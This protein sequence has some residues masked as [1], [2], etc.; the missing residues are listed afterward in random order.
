MRL[1]LNRFL[2]LL[3]GAAL[4]SSLSLG[5][6][7]ALVQGV[8]SPKPD[9][10][11]G[12]LSP[13][14]VEFFEKKIRPVLVKHCDSCHSGSTPKGGLS[15][16]TRTGILKGGS[17]GPAAVSGRP[18]ESLLV[19]AVH[20]TDPRVK[21]PPA[22]KLSGA[23]IADLEKWV[24]M[25]L[26]DP[27]GAT[28]AA[29]APGSWAQAV[30]ARMKWWS[31]QPVRKLKAPP[32]KD[33]RW[34]DHPIDRFILAKL[35][36]VKLR[37][38]PDADKYALIRR[39]SLALSGMP[40]TNQEIEAFVKDASPTAYEKLV[41]RLLASPHFGE[42]WAR[43]WMDVVRYG[44]THGYEW[45]YEIRDPWRYRD[46]LIRA[47]NQ[48][49]PYDRFIREHIAGDLLKNPR[50]NTAERTN[51]SA[52]GTAFYRFGEVG[53]DAFKEIG[54]DVL[55]NQVDTLS[56]AFQATTVACARCHDH[57]LDAVSTRDYY[58][59]LGILSSSRQVIHTLDTRE[60]N[61]EPKQRLRD[62]KPQIRAELAAVWLRDAE[63]AGK[64]L[65]AAQASKDKA[66]D[67][68]MLAQGLDANR[69]KSLTA[70]LEA[71][72]SP[73]EDPLNPWR[74]AVESKDG[75]KAAWE[76]LSARYTKE[77]KE[78]LEFNA[79]KFEPFGEF[80]AND[81]AGWRA[82]GMGL[83]DG[84]SK[85][86]DFA[87]AAQG[88]QAVTGVLPAGLFT[89]TLS[90]RMN[91]SLRSPF[92]PKEK[93][94][95]SLLVMG[96][97]AAFLRTIPDFR[98]LAD[99]NREIKNDRPTWVHFGRSERDDKVYLEV[100]TRSDN[101]RSVE[102]GVAKAPT[103]ED[104]RSYFGVVKAVLH[105]GG[106]TP[107][108][109]LQ[110]FSR[111]FQ[112]EAPQNVD[113]VGGRYATSIKVAVEAWAADK[114]TDADAGLIDAMVR[115]GLLS[116]SMS[117]G[118]KL[119]ELVAQ[120][121]E[122]ESKLQT[123]RVVAGMADM[124]DAFDHAVFVRGDYKT[125]GEVARRSYV[126]AICKA[127]SQERDVEGGSGRL[128]LA[129]KIANPANPLTA[130]VMVNRIWHHLFGSGLVRT[131]DDFGHMGEKPSHPE[132][133]D[134]L[135]GR[136]VEDGWSVK[137]LIR[138]IVLSRTFRLSSVASPQEALADPQNRLL[139]HYPARRLTAE[140]I[141]DSVLTTSG[142]LDRTL[143]GPS[144]DP[145]REKP[146]PERKLYSGPLDG[147]GRRSLYTKITLMEGPRFLMAFNFPDPK[148]AQGKRDVTNVPAQ[149]LALLNDPF[150]T[151]QASFWAKRLVTEQDASAGARV[152][153]MVVAAL[154]R[155]ATQAEVDRFE[156]FIRDLTSLHSVPPDGILKSEALWKDV[157]HAVFNLK[158]F[159]YIR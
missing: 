75:L 112:G 19:K 156:A 125:P 86:G 48:D 63:G 105:D 68:Q 126:E 99:E 83:W 15:L 140:S 108:D 111:L 65:R 80:S 103:A 40:P 59:M 30:E 3:T 131:T 64:Y 12:V 150:V 158:E 153:R 24:A 101:P 53:H 67:A 119:S 71:K 14:A 144:I 8:S 5:G 55:D 114:A 82:D 142:R 143:F 39:A 134:Y 120:Y 34:S 17:K 113:Q 4:L 130:R 10:A 7:A 18:E 56:K 87:V 91:G 16:A 38:A 148:V 44:E 13:A 121:R 146:T 88:E 2:S 152:R 11:N 100:L 27:R 9:S 94:H 84:A 138:S 77:Q 36:G 78:R 6:V 81:M 33:A 124:N 47:Y 25:G 66:P 23:T 74:A 95:L 97:K 89:H 21:M 133:L 155:P 159:I 35:E 50:L 90:E 132:L 151:D 20:Y 117:A 72:D 49:V 54:Y 62:L 110:S 116:N 76:Q 107:K 127:S 1:D 118:A 43:H 85:S 32:V 129:E 51:E 45:N 28:P 122:V 141:R 135:A 70:A 79:T 145:Y 69:L 22:G 37:P 60:V 136:F 147:N 115:R 93:K 154:T 106:E 52:I 31:L 29:P 98:Q 104:R 73:L 92:W 41:D 139:H 46:Y 96:G 149:A 128:D 42:Q 137:R 109:D 58:A 26:P 157:A 123:P 57:K 102:R 61:A